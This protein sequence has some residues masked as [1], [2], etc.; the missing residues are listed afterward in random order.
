MGQ[1]KWPCTTATRLVIRWVPFT[2]ILSTVM[3]PARRKKVTPSTE[4][5]TTQAAKKKEDASS[6]NASDGENGRQA[7]NEINP[8]KRNLRDRS[9]KT[10]EGEVSSKNMPL[11]KKNVQISSETRTL[12]PL[13]NK[14]AAISSEN[15]P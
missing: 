7:I 4:S 14:K 8:P 1:F 9:I 15:M 11:K 2:R 10:K 3:P 5:S 12:M 13:K 6:K